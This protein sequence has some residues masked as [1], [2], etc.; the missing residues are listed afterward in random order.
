MFSMEMEERML[1]HAKHICDLDPK[2]NNR[3]GWGSCAL[4]SPLQC[5]A[6]LQVFCKRT[7]PVIK[8]KALCPNS[9]ASDKNGSSQS[10]V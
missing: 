2:L 7:S 10:F 6:E 8:N 5:I 9:F 1:V 3:G 4:L